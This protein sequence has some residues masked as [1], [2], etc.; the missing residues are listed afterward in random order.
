M[1]VQFLF[2]TLIATVIGIGP[3]T[4]ALAVQTGNKKADPTEKAPW[5]VSRV[6]YPIVGS[7][8]AEAGGISMTVQ[9][10]ASMPALH[11][12]FDRKRLAGESEDYTGSFRLTDPE[13]PDSKEIP[14]FGIGVSSG[15]GTQPINTRDFDK[16]GKLPP[17]A[18]VVFESRAASVKQFYVKRVGDPKFMFSL[19]TMKFVDPAVANKSDNANVPKD[20][21]K[22]AKG[23]S[24][25]GREVDFPNHQFKFKVPKGWTIAK[26]EDEGKD[27]AW[28]VIQEQSTKKP[29][30]TVIIQ[31]G[32]KYVKDAPE[33]G[34]L[35]A[36]KPLAAGA[37]AMKKAMAWG[38]GDPDKDPYGMPNVVNLSANGYGSTTF[39]SVEGTTSSIS[40]LGL[41]AEDRP[42]G[43]L[44]VGC[45]CSLNSAQ[46]TQQVLESVLGKRIR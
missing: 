23:V 19:Q 9:I 31:A 40:V 30:A 44:T 22:T 28:C 12:Q 24:K 15:K 43:P 45:F 42:G 3:S 5:T 4:S 6:Y 11:F 37:S 17:T 26:Y 36:G 33:S 46:K 27:H 18:T 10:N 20:E 7:H 25:G 41:C 29:K 39:L 14:V 13:D 34:N 2:S 32:A 38:L 21:P 35:S 1:F 16:N 8:V